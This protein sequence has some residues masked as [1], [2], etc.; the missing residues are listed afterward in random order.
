MY[1]V[2]QKLMNQ[3]S[4]YKQLYANKNGQHRREGQIL[5]KVQAFKTELRSHRKYAQTNRRY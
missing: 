5:R 2:F 3:R 4:Y 1:I